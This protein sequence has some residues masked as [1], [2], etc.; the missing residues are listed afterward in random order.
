MIKKILLVDD[1]PDFRTVFKAIL[2]NKEY[3]VVTA[4]NADDGLKIAIE[5]KPDL[6]LLDILM[7][8]KDG[9]AAL[10]ELKSMDTTKNIPVVMLTVKGD[11]KSRDESLK[12]GAR[13]YILKT[14]DA[15]AIMTNIKLSLSELKKLDIKISD[16]LRNATD[17]RKNFPCLFEE[18]RNMCKVKYNIADESI[19]IENPR[20]NGCNYK[21]TYGTSLLCTC[22]LRKYIYFNYKI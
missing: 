5:E 3:K 12:L 10:K 15:D 17:C 13:D 2:E 4:S 11:I 1:E 18:T 19:F 20:G 21:T 14:F 6:I 22:P 16:A 8:D 9:I 7:P